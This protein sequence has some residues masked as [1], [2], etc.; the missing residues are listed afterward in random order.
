V[1]HTPRSDSRQGQEATMTATILQRTPPGPR[2]HL[3]LGHLPEYQR[4]PLTL[5][6]NAALRYGGVV[7]LRFAGR[8]VFFVNHPDAIKHVLQDNNRNYHKSVG[9]EKTRPMLGY[10]LL[11]SED[12]FWRRQRRLAQ[13]AFHRKQIGAFAATMTD[14]TA[15]MLERWRAFAASGRTF[16]VAQ[17]MMRLTLTIVGK[18]LFSSDVSGEADTVGRALTIALEHTNKRMQSLFDL[19]EKLPLPENRRFDEAIA[20]LDRVVYGMIEE[21]RRG[22][23]DEYHDLLSLLLHAQDDD[24]GERMSDKQLRDEAMT[25]FLAGHETTAN[26][27]SWAWVLLSKHPDVL[28]KLQAEVDTVLAGRAPTLDDLPQLRYTR[29]VLDEVLRLYP[30]AW[31]IGRNTI[32]DDTIID[33]HVPANSIVAMSAYVTHRLPQFW[34]NPEGFDPERFAPGAEE[35]R[36]RFAYFPFGGGPRLCIG[37][38]FALMEAVLILA[39]VVQRFRLDLVPGHPI[40]PE[41]M[42]TLRPRHGVLV[43]LHAR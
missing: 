39:M 22:T 15:Q 17:E 41:P 4:D 26:A 16:D 24:T 27:L 23:H 35:K 12:D 32:G 3:L 31:A 10:G 14:A 21:R 36:P 9:Y 2:G 19:G 28:R 13:P 8:H 5:F 6:M 25:I 18:T 40:E 34:P 11:T 33:Y 29:M 20:T 42:V 1:Y 30:P 38:N 37:N 43:T 7:R